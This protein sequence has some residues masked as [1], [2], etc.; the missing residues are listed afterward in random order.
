M[1]LA[2]WSTMHGRGSTA[3][4]V[5]AAL[6]VS[7]NYN[8]HCL[9]TNTQYTMSSLDDAFFSKKEREDLKRYD[10]GI[11]SIDRLVMGK[12]IV[13]KNDFENYASNVVPGRLDILTGSQR[14]NQNIYKSSIKETILEILNSSRNCYDLTFADV[15]SGMNDEITMKIL[16]SS[17]VIVVSLDQNEKVISDF[18]E[19]DYNKVKEKN[20][21]IVLSKYD[22]KSKC[23]KSYVKSLFNFK[24][25]IFGVPYNTD[26]LDALNNHSVYEYFFSNNK[27]VRREK[28]DFFFSE[29]NKIVDRIFMLINDDRI[30]KNPIGKMDIYMQL[31]NLIISKAKVVGYWVN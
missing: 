7:M 12:R 22:P 8:V 23:S 15:N 6:G 1:Q 5:A 24:D 19:N 4:C 3:N 18:F 27:L 26:F 25:Y 14:A 20:L 11:D 30:E 9:I 2:F 21:I 16:D 31:K 10:Y 13:S 28:D 17:D 29:V